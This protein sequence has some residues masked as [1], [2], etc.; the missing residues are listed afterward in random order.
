MRVIL[1]GIFL[2]VQFAPAASAARLHMKYKLYAVGLQIG[3][4]TMN[5]DLNGGT[6]SVSAEGKTSAFG[7]LV[8]DG[9][10]SVNSAGKLATGGLSPGSYSLRVSS[11]DETGTV[12]MKLGSGKA[13]NIAVNPPQDRVNERIKVT[14]EH[15]SGILDPLSAA[16]LPAPHGLKKAS[17]NRTLELFDGKERYNVHL[18]YKRHHRSSTADG[19]FR[20][21]VL[22]CRA[23][24][25]PVAGHRPKRKTIQQLA[26]NKS[27][28]VWLAPIGKTPYLIPL[29]ASMRAPFGPL[30]VQADKYKFT[31]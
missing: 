21:K 13:R 23:R 24:Y 19:R 1:L 9:E 14:A 17:C 25:E 27:L 4:G 15:L 10:G 26:A 11:E 2:L 6:Y 12:S 31:D 22:V 28:E 16:V 5:V 3:T 20:G 18:S 7:R 8:S 29:R 30:V